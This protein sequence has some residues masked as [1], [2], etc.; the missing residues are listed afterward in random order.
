MSLQEH[1]KLS[2]APMLDWTDRH[3][4]YFLRLISKEI[5]LYTEMVTTFALLHGDP[6]RFLRHDAAETPVAL[7][8]GG[9]T[10]AD[11]AACARMGEDAG[12][13]E[14]N[15]NCG[16]PSDRVQ[17]GA[18]GACLMRE[19]D[20]VAEGVA[21]MKAAV[22]IPVTVKTRIGI[23]HDDSWE[24]FSH[25]LHTVAKAGCSDF[26]VHARKAWLKGLS[27]KE[28]REIPPL[29]Y[30]FAYR[31]KSE[32][33]QWNISVNGGVRSLAAVENLLQGKGVQDLV[34]D[35]GG[36]VGD[37]EVVAP[38]PLDGVMVGR[39][40]YE[41]PW[42]LATAD[43]RIFGKPDQ[44]PPSQKALLEAYY[45]YVQRQ[46]DDG[47]PLN[48][49]TRHLMGMFTGLKG[50]RRFRQILSESSTRPGAGL[51]VLRQA[52]AAVEEPV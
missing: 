43:S 42:F 41:N 48:I 6:N 3:E 35:R 28:N 24:F 7:Q 49:M 51:D 38:V 17:S 47:C 32:N 22:K 30:G 33:P 27:P 13:Q 19:A 23:D 29:N 9:S 2:I 40:A 45:P 26:I 12:Y 21:A 46:L 1:R 37:R 14:I 18:F 34:A 5:L 31:I 20:K 36:P 44:A 52:V 8:L 15:L 39:E 50:A 11:L 4:R 10:P 16:C 25:F